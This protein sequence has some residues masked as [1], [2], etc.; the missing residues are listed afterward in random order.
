MG[1]RKHREPDHQPAPGTVIVFRMRTASSTSDAALWAHHVHQHMAGNNQFPARLGTQGHFKSMAGL[2]ELG[3]AWSLR[4]AGSARSAPRRLLHRREM[5]T[6]QVH[7]V[8]IKRPVDH[9]PV[10]GLT[11]R[12]VK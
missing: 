10:V 9:T 7:G 8:A 3:T 4:S 12:G 2:N 1:S 6:V 11:G 5:E